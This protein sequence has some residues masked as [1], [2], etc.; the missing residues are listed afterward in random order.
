MNILLNE[1]QFKKLYEELSREEIDQRAN[2]AEFNPTQKQKE[3]GN[4]KM[5]HVRIK[6]F[7]ITIENPIGSRRYYGK[8]KKKYVVMQNH[9]GY[10]SRTKGKDWLSGPLCKNGFFS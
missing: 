9:Y 2:E 7:D 10:F 6:G 4:Y 5:G 3:A 8:D 1:E